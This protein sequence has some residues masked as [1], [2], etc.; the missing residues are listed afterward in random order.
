VKI[1]TEIE[2]SQRMN[3]RRVNQYPNNQEA[4]GDQARNN[5]ILRNSGHGH[6]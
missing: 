4:A 5:R 3:E 6:S 2:M 1:E